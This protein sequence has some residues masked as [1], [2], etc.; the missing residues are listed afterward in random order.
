M[1]MD[2]VPRGPRRRKLSLTGVG[3]TIGLI[4]IGVILAA[5]GRLIEEEFDRSRAM[6]QAVEQSFERR[7]RL[8]AVL[9]THQ[10]IEIGQRGYV[11][12]GNKTFLEPYSSATA[13]IERSVADL[14]AA[15]G[16]DFPLRGDMT[17]LRALSMKK[18]RFANQTIL[19]EDRGR[20]GEAVALIA[21]GKG[22]SL[23]DGI[24]AVIGRMDRLEREQLNARLGL[25]N[26]ASGKAQWLSIALQSVLLLLLAV[27]SLIIGR[28][29]VAKRAVLRRVQDLNARQAAIF[30]AAKDGI[31]VLNS[32]GSI[33]SLNP[34]AAAL[35]GY[36]ADEL[37]RRDVGTLFE[38]APDRGLIETFVKRMQAGGRSESGYIQEFW[39]KRKDGST[40][41]GD[42]AVSPVQLADSVKYVA[43]I[44]D[45]TERKQVEQMKTEFVSTV[46]HELRTP[47]TSI[48]GSLGLLAGGAAGTLPAPAARLVTVARNNSQRL[49]RLINDILD[50]E[51]IESGKMDFDVQPVAL[52]GLLEQVV[53]ANRG[54]A[55]EH[56]AQ[57]ELEDVPPG[58]RV[59]ADPDRLAQVVTNLISNAA[60]F[61]PLEAPVRIRV[62]RLDRR[63]RIS[64]ADRGPGIPEAF[65]A[66]MFDK[67]AQADSSDARQKGGTG[68]GLSIVREIVTGLAGTVS[69]E[70]RDGG[71]AIFHVDLPMAPEAAHDATG[72]GEDDGLPCI[73]HVED[74]PDVLR[75]AA[76]A[77]EG[78]AHVQAAQS[79]SEARAVL[80]AT[81]ID[82]VVLDLGLP[83][84]SGLDLLEELRL[85]SEGAPKIV[86]F[87]AEEPG[88]RST[89]EADALLTKCSATLD[90]LVQTA[91]RLSAPPADERKV[92]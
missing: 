83:D 86:I 17:M 59:M 31:I 34:A 36:A 1:K 85:R 48:V 33:E 28:N 75:V 65:E 12:T 49:I 25:S 61:S 9:S 40:F 5:T 87:S 13:R 23:M 76:R 52:R 14:E 89:A 10:D 45:I 30:D 15:L 57:L 44:R 79:L 73:L 71:G 72:L 78:R 92:A 32:S 2:R 19:L 53:E 38:V 80:A 6:R 47:L 70:H 20:R 35:Y 60:K 22:K 67:F 18:L 64:V 46:S 37:I 27:A 7:A 68:L 4:A 24:R 82:V 84:G 54:F 3:V 8:Q 81:D 43:I 63:Y 16:A 50:V 56:Q 90:Q 21:G 26:Q 88:P 77:F 74:D 41:P 69:L 62:L 58:A 66:R 51:K 42:V 11:L 55:A 91:L 39:G 29:L